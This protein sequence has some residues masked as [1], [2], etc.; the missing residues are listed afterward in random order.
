MP[1]VVEE[2]LA[3]VYQKLPA[4]GESAQDTADAALCLALV[5]LRGGSATREQIHADMNEWIA[6]YGEP[7]RRRLERWAA[8]LDLEAGIAAAALRQQGDPRSHNSGEG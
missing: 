4:A 3:D 6:A 1:N 2:A 5:T 8:G 7:T